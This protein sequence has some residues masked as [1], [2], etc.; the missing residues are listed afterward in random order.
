MAQARI[1]WAQTYLCRARPIT[2]PF[3]IF[4]CKEG[5]N[6]DYYLLSYFGIFIFYLALL[7][8]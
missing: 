6:I 4:C 1:T 7:L 3:F 5:E 8:Q 2:N